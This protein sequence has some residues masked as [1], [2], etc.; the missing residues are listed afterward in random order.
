[1][2]RPGLAGVVAIASVVGVLLRGSPAGLVSMLPNIFPAAVIFGAMGWH[3]TIVDIG[4][5]MT[6]SVAM[7]IAVDDTVH[8]LTW[9]RR[10]MREGCNRKEA[11]ML[12]YERCAKAMFQTTM[13]AGLGLSVFALSSFTPTQRFGY[14]MLTMLTAALLGDLLLLPAILAGPVGKFFSRRLATPAAGTVLA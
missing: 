1:M 5:M 11:T 2:V 13:I 10:G 7:G 3:G 12:A 14:L 8:F 9:F 6:A 4:A